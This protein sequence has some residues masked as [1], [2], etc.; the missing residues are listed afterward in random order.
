MIRAAK[1]VGA[2]KLYLKKEKKNHGRKVLSKVVLKP[3]QILCSEGQGPGAR[4][5]ALQGGQQQK[6]QG[7]LLLA[8]LRIL[9]WP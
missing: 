9:C 3:L 5:I 2:A 4:V 6:T 8:H 7:W 1:K